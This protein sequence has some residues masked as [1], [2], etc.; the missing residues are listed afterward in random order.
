VIR[1]ENEKGLAQ[2]LVRRLMRELTAKIECLRGSECIHDLCCDI[3]EFLYAN[4]RPPA[5]SFF[6]QRLESKMKEKALGNETDAAEDYVAAKVEDSLLV[7][8]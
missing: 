4:N 1:L 8:G 3:E 2:D 7:G 6:E 5:K